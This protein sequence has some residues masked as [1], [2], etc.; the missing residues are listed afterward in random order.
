MAYLK[1]NENQAY[2]QS[3]LTICELPTRR[4]MTATPVKYK[5]TTQESANARIRHA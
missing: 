4:P 5:D 1:W 3:F 2:E